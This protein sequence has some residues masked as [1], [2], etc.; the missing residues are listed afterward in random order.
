MLFL[1]SLSLSPLTQLDEAG[2]VFLM[3]MSI[4]LE[5]ENVS[6]QSYCGK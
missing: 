4:P 1:L 5:H 2:P 3:M 6:M